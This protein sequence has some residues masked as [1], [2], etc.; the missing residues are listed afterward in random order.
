MFG[1]TQTVANLNVLLFEK[2]RKQHA[3]FFI[4]S[5]EPEK[6]R[7]ASPEGRTAPAPACRASDNGKIFSRKNFMRWAEFEVWLLSLLPPGVVYGMVRV[8][9]RPVRRWRR[10]RRFGACAP[11]TGGSI[12]A[13]FWWAWTG[14]ILLCAARPWVKKPTRNIFTWPCRTVG[15]CLIPARLRRNNRRIA[16]SEGKPHKTPKGRKKSVPLAFWLV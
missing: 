9:W 12:R 3:K 13:V 10:G 4:L 1:R 15:D 2:S 5:R 16:L 11:R 7:Q 14:P 8:V 6:T